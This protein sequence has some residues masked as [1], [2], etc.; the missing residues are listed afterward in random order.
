MIDTQQTK[1]RLAS[2]LTGVTLRCFIGAERREFVRR[3]TDGE[4]VILK[5]GSA[6][7][8]ERGNGSYV[9]PAPPADPAEN[10][11]AKREI[12]GSVPFLLRFF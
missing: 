4:F 5:G 11:A 10:V 8:V 2:F 6:E 3:K 9:M 1:P 7:A 12:F